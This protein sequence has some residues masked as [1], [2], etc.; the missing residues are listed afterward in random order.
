MRRFGYIRRQPQHA[1]LWRKLR[2]AKARGDRVE[3]GRLSALIRDR[4]QRGE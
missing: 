2:K 3:V 4:V 1:R